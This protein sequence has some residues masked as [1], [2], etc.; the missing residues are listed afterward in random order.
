MRTAGLAA[1]YKALANATQSVILAIYSTRATMSAWVC[2]FFYFYGGRDNWNL[3][4]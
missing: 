4:H 1:I 3:G 2:L